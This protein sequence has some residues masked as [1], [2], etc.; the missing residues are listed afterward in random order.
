MTE[1]EHPTQHEKMPVFATDEQKKK[2]Y[3]GVMA[4]LLFLTAATS[5]MVRSAKED[6]P[7]QQDIISTT[8]T[9]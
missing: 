5:I 8:D 1:Q 3:E 4:A 2:F 9:K 6:Y 7:Q